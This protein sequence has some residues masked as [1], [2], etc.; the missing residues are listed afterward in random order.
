MAGDNENAS[1]ANLIRIIHT[2]P[3]AD[4]FRVLA[5]RQEGLT[6]AEAGENLLRF[7][8]N[9]LQKIRGKPLYLK[10]FANFTHLMAILLWV[11]GIIAF[12]AQMPQLGVAVWIV[13]IINGL[14]SFWQEYRA[15][16]ATEALLKLLPH[17]VRV[18]REG[19]EQVILSEGLVP[20]DLILIAEGDHISADGPAACPDKTAFCGG[21][22]GM[23]LC[24]LH[25]QDRDA[26]PERDDRKEP[27]GGA[28]KSH[29]NRC[30]LCPGR[31]DQ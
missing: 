20:G 30:R 27:L 14:F 26:H 19:K 16:K 6:S 5:T 7:G 17:Q 3:P 1:I 8:P 2:L 29:G 15:E 9:A 28:P 4:V 12:I 22:V 18:V 25:G 23:Y 21:N 11:G 10:F 13:N 31:N 24:H